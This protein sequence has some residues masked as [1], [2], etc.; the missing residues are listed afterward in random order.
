MVYIR[1]TKYLWS[2]YLKAVPGNPYWK[3]RLFTVYLL[4]VTGLDYLLFMSKTFT[5]K[6]V[7][8][9]GRP[10]VL[11]RLVTYKIHF[12]LMTFYIIFLP[13]PT[14]DGL[15]PLTLGWGASVLPLLHPPPLSFLLRL[16]WFLSFIFIFFFEDVAN[17]RLGK[18]ILGK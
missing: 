7:T 12:I 15:E 10:T 18:P 11:N 9:I 1:H 3:G 8:S 14:P 13:V 17:V 2:W 4:V 5:T 6:Q 16:G